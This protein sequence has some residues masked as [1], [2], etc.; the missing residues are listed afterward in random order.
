MATAVEE[1]TTSKPKG[2]ANLSPEQKKAS[3]LRRDAAMLERLAAGST[4]PQSMLDQ[5]AKLNAEA[6]ALAPRA[7]QAGPIELTEA[8]WEK[9][10]THI[11]SDFRNNLLAVSSKTKL[12]AIATGK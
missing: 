1:Q 3:A 5:A 9:I 10:E 4:N 11:V 7:A 8:D 12:K 2:G 6:D